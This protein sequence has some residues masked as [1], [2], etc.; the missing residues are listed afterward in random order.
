MIRGGGRGGRVTLAEM[1]AV[2]ATMVAET[3]VT[4]AQAA[5][6]SSLLVNVGQGEFIAPIVL[7][8]DST[9]T[10]AGQLAT[11]MNRAIEAT[12]LDG[13]V[14]FGTR[15]D[16][17]ALWLLDGVAR[18]VTVSGPDATSV[19]FI[20]GQS[21]YLGRPSLDGSLGVSL[22]VKLTSPLNAIPGGG[23]LQSLILSPNARVE[24]RVAVDGFEAVP[25]VLVRTVEMDELSSLGSLR[26]SHIKALFSQ[27][28]G[29]LR[30]FQSSSDGAGKS[31]ESIR[32]PI[33]DVDLAA[34]FDIEGLFDRLDKE[35]SGRAVG[36][37]AEVEAL[38]E[39]L[40]ANL[41]VSGHDIQLAIDH[42]VASRP[43]LRVDLSLDQTLLSRHAVNV[44]LDSLGLNGVGDLVGVGGGAQVELSSGAALHLGLGIDL[45]DAEPFVYADDT[46]L[47]FNALALADDLEFE[48]SLGPL[49]L[50]VRDRQGRESGAAINGG[51]PDASVPASF[52]V[53]LEA[54]PGERLPIAGPFQVETAF[55]AEAFAS[56]PLYFPTETSHL[57]TLE[58]RHSDF[59]K[60]P[61]A[62]SL[63]NLTEVREAIQTTI[64]NV[65]P[66]ELLL[67][68]AGGWK[69]ISDLILD[70]MRGEVLG[71]SLPLVGDALKAEADFLEDARDRV[72][73]TL[74]E[75]ADQGIDAVKQG[76]VQLLGPDGANLLRDQNGDGRIGVA[77]VADRVADDGRE[78]EFELLLGREPV[79]LSRPIGFA[80][81]VP[82]LNLSLDRD[83][84]FQIDLGFD[85]HLTLGASVD[86]GFYLDTTRPSD[87]PELSVSLDVSMPGLAAD[88][89][90]A[91]LQVELT[92]DAGNPSR[93]SGQLGIDLVDPG[94]LPQPP[95]RSKDDGRLTVAE[96][97]ATSIVDIFRPVANAVADVN[98][99]IETN[100][101]G[102]TALPTITAD[103]L[104]DWQFQPS[105]ESIGATEPRI[106]F[107]N[108]QLDLGD[109][110]SRFTGPV[111]NQ[112]QD[113]LKPVQPVVDV[114]ST[115][116]PV[117]SDLSGSD[118]TLIDVARIFGR[119]DVAGFAQAVVDVN[120]LIAALPR[121]IDD[122][123]IDL[124]GFLVSG[125]VPNN[126]A[127]PALGYF[128]L[129]P[130]VDSIAQASQ[131]DAAA[132]RIRQ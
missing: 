100:V 72:L 43:A 104:L 25:D 17:M 102:H 51:A 64:A 23:A 75:A 19:G 65:D 10:E 50:F 93:L 8:A 76:F 118:V 60:L 86:D 4:V 57:T 106:E 78:V 56:L 116:L 69:G 125:A 6:A 26:L 98:L 101:N 15:G 22:P 71:V 1:S 131:Q 66:G 3:S 117:L 39:D 107:D 28:V 132:G 90:L 110:L 52:V 45:R 82:G 108:V 119:A 21:A 126:D 109:F 49:G 130:S 121:N 12:A 44:G 87:D 115:R 59:S 105:D 55:N 2:E 128:A 13:I 77:D 74:D 46:E 114:L 122:L 53:G 84:S 112:I 81:G 111:L 67:S 54:S 48:V 58:F 62:G 89:R 113:V 14:R 47:E 41:G 11:A 94:S 38:L 127:S 63:P 34:T 97:G 9:R 96:L 27:L 33:V 70:T 16:K 7:A 85:W 99:S 30:S 42:S 40:L 32:L 68:M 79:T 37:L 103:I 5:G 20:D 80:L 95:N 92:D 91:F 18:R 88:G 24:A 129:P 31:L 29:F 73:T 120:D 124:G 35:L 83:A 61:N 36:H 123:Q